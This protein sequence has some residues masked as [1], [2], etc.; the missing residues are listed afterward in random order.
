RMEPSGGVPPG[1]QVLFDAESRDVKAVDRV[2]G[3]HDQ[4]HIAADGYMQLV[5]LPLPF[6]MLK[7]PHPL[8]CYGVNF[9]GTSW[10]GTFLKVN[11]GTPHK[12][13]QED[14]PGDNRPREL[15]SI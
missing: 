4:A 14:A 8:F 6:R 12:N 1:Q 3:G 2:L 15:K 5:D 7:L 9:G 13:A 10:R 11:V